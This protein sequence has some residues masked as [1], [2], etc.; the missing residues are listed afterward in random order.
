ME[1][2]SIVYFTRK[3]SSEGLITAFDKVKDPLVGKIAV[4]LHTGEK[5]GPNII[6]RSW[7]EKL[8]KEKLKNATIVETNTLFHGDR[9][10]TKDSIETALH[11]GW[12]F[13]PLDILDSEG[14]IE[15]P[16]NPHKW[17]DKITVGSHTTNYDSLLV[18]THFKG[19]VKGGFGGANKNIA[20]GMADGR[21][22]K[23]QIHSSFK[24]NDP[25]DIERDEFMERM[26]ESTKGTLDSFNHHYTFVNVMRNMSV[27]C[28]CE[29]IKAKPV[30]T[31]NVGILSSTDI[32]AIDKACVDIVYAMKESE[33]HDLVERIETRRGLRQL[34]YMDEL[35]LGNKNY[36]ILDLDNNLKEISVKDCVLNL[37]PFKDDHQ[38]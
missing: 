17:L 33:N 30:V 16:I 28:D 37:K 18:L 24:S 38:K 7:V 13:A 26:V 25:Y 9:Y 14:T 34:T 29:G 4:K 19:H 3:L 1:E 20:I 23:A 11:N 21:I 35:K 6:P 36:K 15:L 32:L 22:G 31:P 5:D 8:F 12:T 27:S 2:K 10:E